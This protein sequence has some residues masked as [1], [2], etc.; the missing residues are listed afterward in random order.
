MSKL[1]FKKNKTKLTV[2]QVVQINEHMGDLARHDPAVDA[3]VLKTTTEL[4]NKMIDQ[5]FDIDRE[6]KMISQDMNKN[7]F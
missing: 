4:G 6:V 3:G 1:F 2:G 5:Y 7:D